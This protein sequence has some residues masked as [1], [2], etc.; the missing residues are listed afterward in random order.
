[1]LVIEPLREGHQPISTAHQRDREL[2]D[3][4]AIGFQHG[5]ECAGVVPELRQDSAKVILDV[6]KL[7]GIKVTHLIHVVP[8]VIEDAGRHG[9]AVVNTQRILG[10][11]VQAPV[12]VTESAQQALRDDVLLR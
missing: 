7:L 2:D 8:A 9:V 5:Q 12:G 1:M 3:T 10:H 6:P 11:R 4:L